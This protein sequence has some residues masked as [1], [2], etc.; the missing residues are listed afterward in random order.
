MAETTPYV[1]QTWVDGVSTCS[2]AR[3]TY[4]EEGISAAHLQPSV[5]V[6]HNA[7]QSITTATETALAFNSERW[8]TAFGSAS[9]QHDT[10]TNNS[11]LTAQYAGKYLVV[12]HV[13]F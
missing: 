2:A 10:A 6:F 5:R 3:N 11:R 4:Q 1:K 9:T 12:G 13:G 7:T 8:D